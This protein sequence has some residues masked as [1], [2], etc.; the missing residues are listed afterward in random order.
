MARPRSREGVRLAVIADPHLPGDVEPGPKAT[1]PTTM[2]RRALADAAERDADA[3]LMLG[4][5][6]TD[7]R[8]SEFDAF[9][10]A[11]ADCEIPWF[12][13]PGNHDAPKAFDEHA[14]ISRS[15]FV[16]RYP[17][18]ALP[19][20]HRLGDID[21]VG[22]DSGF[23][24]SVS[25]T[26]NGSL[27]ER[28]YTWLDDTLGS[29]ENP[30]VA[31]HHPGPGIVEA[32]E[33]FRREDGRDLVDVTHLHGGRTLVDILESHDVPLV[34]SGH[35]H[36]LAVAGY[37]GLMEVNVASSSTF[38]SSYL[39]LEITAD[40]TVARYVGLGDLD[41]NTAAFMNRTGILPKADALATMAALRIAS[42]PLDGDH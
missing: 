32:Y 28:Q 24:A 38:P 25:E 6:T 20:V 34:L 22:L 41:E 8:A 33:A 31:V 29:L 2:F 35:L 10:R 9:D 17:P 21:L 19:Y 14:G 42:F 37:V 15:T 27:D 4:D 1:Q 12:V 18:G 30:L 23:P 11:M 36:T 40:G 39:L 16:E 7:G 5:L 3:V 13:I 26:H